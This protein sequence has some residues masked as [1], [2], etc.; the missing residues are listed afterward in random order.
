MVADDPKVQ[1]VAKLGSERT[2][3]GRYTHELAKGLAQR[4]IDVRVVVPAPA[5]GKMAALG[6]RIGLDVGSFFASYPLHLP[7]SRDR[8]VHLPTQT[9]ATALWTARSHGP[10]A[11]TVLDIIPW[12][13]R[14]DATLRVFR[15]FADER[16]Y[17]AALQG[18]R[19]ADV[20]LAISD[21]AKQTLIEVLRLPSERI[22]VTYLGV[23]TDIFHPQPTRP[24]VLDRYGL[25]SEGCRVL[26]VGS[27][28]PR[29]NLPTL[30]RA[31]ALAR[32]QRNDLEL[33]KVGAAH[34]DTERAKLNTLAAELGISD[35]V[36]FVG[37]VSDN[38]L[39]SLYSCSQ[40]LV[41]PSWYEGFG[42][43]VLEAMA[44]GT[45]VVISDRTSLPEI[46]GPLALTVDP[47][48]PDELAHA[49]LSAIDR[50][51][52]PDNLRAHAMNFSW[53]STVDQTLAAY[54]QVWVA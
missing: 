48:A 45:P 42:L 9:M 26:Y 49:I 4:G 43:P 17:W 7:M 30:F 54:R 23:D 52:S 18:L 44:C 40:V 14:H 36:K 8:L 50:P 25:R 46:G 3:T 38:D 20:I 10:V 6:R 33:I 35:A 51:P 27:E 37:S 28:D 1:L 5:Q 19:R 2:G 39:S 15:H 41:L 53:Q 16:F 24:D 32:R 47:S 21:Y 22:W 11:V 12:L 13:V 31:F 34:F 29:K